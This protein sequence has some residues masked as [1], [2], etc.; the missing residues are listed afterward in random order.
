MMGFTSVGAFLTVSIAMGG[1]AA[2]AAGRAVAR[3]WAPRWQLVFY[4]VLL[5]AAVRFL[6]FA[7]FAGPLLSVLGFFLDLAVLAAFAAA[8]FRVTRAG[9]MARQY[10]WLFERTS[11]LTW[12]GREEHPHA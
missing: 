9:Q 3:T 12:R 11:P 8:G 5:A 6:H 1:A 10:P 2:W 4:T 7:L